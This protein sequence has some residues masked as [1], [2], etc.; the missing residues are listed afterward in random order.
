MK[1]V[2]EKPLL[3]GTV[4][5]ILRAAM[6]AVTLQAQQGG[7]GDQQSRARLHML[8]SLSWHP[9]SGILWELWAGHW[10][11]CEGEV[12]KVCAY[13]WARMAFSP[14]RKSC[15]EFWRNGV[16]GSCHQFEPRWSSAS[17]ATDPGQLQDPTEEG[18]LSL[19]QV[20]TYQHINDDK[21]PNHLPPKHHEELWP[22]LAQR[23]QAAS[24]TLNIFSVEES[25][26]FW[27]FS[28]NA[29]Y[30]GWASHHSPRWEVKSL[31]S[32]TNPTQ[33]VT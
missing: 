25:T 5:S 1:P 6:A 28:L 11:H 2:P 15:Q 32:N 26:C 3:P 30:K 17:S 4:E 20:Q 33:G 13:S 31:S 22:A 12:E 9:I 7:H 18:D 29:P 8:T 10:W 23:V 19:N 24:N 16:G 14:H 21:I 27:V